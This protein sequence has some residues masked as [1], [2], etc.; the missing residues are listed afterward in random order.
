MGNILDKIQKGAQRVGNFTGKVTDILGFFGADVVGLSEGRI[1]DYRDHFHQMLN[2]WDFAIPS[3]TLWVVHIPSFP[4]GLFHE[5]NNRSLVNILDLD[6]VGLDSS[7]RK[8]K[9]RKNVKT[10]TRYE[11][12]DTPGGCT[13]AQ[14]VV[15]PGEYSNIR[16]VMPENN[17]GLIPGRVSTGRNPPEN[18]TLEFRETNTSFVDNIVRPW[19][20]MASHYGFVARDPGDIKNIMSTVHVYQFGKTMSGTPNVFRKHWTYYNCV[21]IRLDPAQLT[22]DHDTQNTIMQ[23]QWSYTHHALEQLPDLPM[24][25]VLDQIMGG[26]VMGLLDKVTKGK[27]SDI[28]GKVTKPIDSV[29]NAGKVLK[30]LF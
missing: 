1:F 2:T 11:Y 22:Y 21:P 18:L 27:S 17:R 3:R 25:L 28:I 6:G 12:Q 16:H 9:I 7:D 30:N 13:F 5:S 8:W 29:K 20:I 24:Q 14:G 26:G 15:I 10:L 23:T 4:V 19:S